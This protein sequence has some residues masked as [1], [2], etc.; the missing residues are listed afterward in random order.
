MAGKISEL[1]TL[2]GAVANG[3]DLIEAV[4]I[5]DT[6]MATSGTNKSMTLAEFLLFLS[7]SGLVIGGNGATTLW[8]GTQAQYDAIGTKDGN[9]V[10]VVT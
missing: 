7:A 2:T 3:A 4:D 1:T 6:T 10:Y 8:K 5:S 9:T